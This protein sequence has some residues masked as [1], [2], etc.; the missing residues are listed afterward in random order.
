MMHIRCHIP[1][2]DP[3]ETVDIP[4]ESIEDSLPANSQQHYENLVYGKALCL[5]ERS[6]CEICGNSENLHIEIGSPSNK[7]E[8]QEFICNSCSELGRGMK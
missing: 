7:V 6:K 3:I 2:K 8:E 1:P 4:F 5:S